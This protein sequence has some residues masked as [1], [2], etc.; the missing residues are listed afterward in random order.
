MYTLCFTVEKFSS[1]STVMAICGYF[2]MSLKFTLPLKNTLAVGDALC[3]RDPDT[4][5]CGGGCNAFGVG[6]ISCLEGKTVDLPQ[7]RYPELG[8]ALAHLPENCDSTRAN[9]WMSIQSAPRWA[10]PK[11]SI[12]MFTVLVASLNIF[13][14]FESTSVRDEPNMLTQIENTV[15]TR[16]MCCYKDQDV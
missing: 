15:A 5:V 12:T 16:K 6:N 9:V 11:M 4:W 8:P 3:V 14:G 2:Q 7:Q 10:S 1:I 13:S